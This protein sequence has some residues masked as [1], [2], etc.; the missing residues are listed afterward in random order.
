MCL[1]E[2]QRFL[3][4]QWSETDKDSL[5]KEDEEISSSEIFSIHLGMALNNLLQL[6]WPDG[7]QKAP[8]DRVYWWKFLS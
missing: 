3:L 2:M 6:A 1:Q 4:W 8:G 5:E 7:W